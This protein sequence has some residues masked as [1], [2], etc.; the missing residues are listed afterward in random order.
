MTP[1][2]IP[3]GCA[4]APVASRALPLATQNPNLRYM[5]AKGQMTVENQ[6]ASAAGSVAA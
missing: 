5:N 2:I 4:D 1:A 3:I 6:P